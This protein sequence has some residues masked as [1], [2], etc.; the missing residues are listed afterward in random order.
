MARVE[1][2]EVGGVHAAIADTQ[3]VPV[4]QAWDG[5]GTASAPAVTGGTDADLLDLFK[6]NKRVLSRSDEDVIAAMTNSR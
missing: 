5:E 2:G 4:G 1:R 6:R 3:P